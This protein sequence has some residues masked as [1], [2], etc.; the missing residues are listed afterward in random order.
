M[1]PLWL[2]FVGAGGGYVIGILVGFMA[3]R[4]YEQ[5]LRK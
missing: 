5:N 1:I 3:G 4:K 2:Y